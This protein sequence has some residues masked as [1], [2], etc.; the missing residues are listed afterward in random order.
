MEKNLSTNKIILLLLD[1]LA[2][3]LFWGGFY[4]FQFGADTLFRIQMPMG[5]IGSCMDHQ[6]YGAYYFL[7][8]LFDLGINVTD[9]YRLFFFVYLISIGLCVWLI[10]LLFLPFFQTKEKWDLIPLLGMLSISALPFFNLLFSETFMFPEFHIVYALAYLPAT[11][12]VLALTRSRWVTGILCITLG[13]LFYQV[14]VTYAAMLITGWLVMEAGYRLNRELVLRVAICDALIMTIGIL[15][16]RSSHWMKALGL[17]E[18]TAES[19]TILPEWTETISRFLKSYLLIHKNSMELM[20]SLW[21]PLIASLAAIILLSAKLLQE[22]K[23][24]GIITLLLLLATEF[25]LL[26]M[27]PVLSGQ[28]CPR[29]TFVF[30]TM[31]AILLLGALSR[32]R[33]ISWKRGFAI[34]CIL[35]LLIQGFFCQRII[36]NR[37]LSNRL[38]E[39]YARLVLQQ[40]RLYEEKTGTQVTQVAISNDAYAP[41]SYEEVKYSHDQVN[42][43]VLSVS[44]YLLLEYMNG[45]E[46]QMRHVEMDPEVFDTHFAGKDWDTFDAS[47]QLVFVD[48]TLYWCVF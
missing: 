4:R 33:K 28:I 32:I 7:K 39:L 24:R 2:V 10:Q 47:E 16:Y 25:L 46:F 17:L 13:C 34:G 12:G 21:I 23:G 31:Q 35:Y 6:R 19:K 45:P 26:A 36:E 43:R 20:P 5:D 14:A 22:E 38:D 30:Y 18:T 1:Q 9:Y 37:Y 44:P 42:E 11:L 41:N 8:L 3:L 27:I 15:D 48:D 29:I 40:I